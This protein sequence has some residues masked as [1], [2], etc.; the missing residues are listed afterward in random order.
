ME[1]P[2]NLLYEYA[3]VRFVPRVDREEFI[4][5]GLIMLNKRNKWLKGKI[6]LEEE[7]IRALYPFADVE[8]LK[9]QSGIFE[10]NDLPAR[11][12]PVEEK[13]RW[14]A[15]VKSSCLQVAPSHPGLL[16]EK[17]SGK[18]PAELM[19]EEFNRLFDNLVS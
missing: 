1:A 19:E 7:R 12:L 11:D 17:D 14:L 8:I 2:D 13:Y 15:A 16:L 9:K 4:N 5:I 10:R 6:K 18:K 3:V